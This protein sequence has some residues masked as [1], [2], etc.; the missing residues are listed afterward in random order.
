MDH[1]TSRR[2]RTTLRGLA[3]LAAGALAAGCAT[4]RRPVVSTWGEIT[5]P[6][7]GTKEQA[8]YDGAEL[9]AGPG[10]VGADSFSG[11]LPN[12]RIVTPAGQSLQ[13]GM[14]PL[15]AILTPDGKFLVTSNDDER[16]GAMPSLRSA[17]VFGG[18]S[19]S[20]IDTA[21]WKVV[22]EVHT[23]G[24]LFLGLA[25]SGAGP[26]T[27]YAAGGADS[28]VK[29]FAIDANGVIGA[30]PTRIPIPVVTS[31]TAGYVSHYV[32]DAAFDKADAHGRKPPVPTGFARSGT[33]AISFPAG[34]ALSPD[35]RCLYVAC[36]GDNSLA[37]LDTATRTVVKQLP[38]GFFPYDVRVS[39]D[40]RSV[41]VT[42][43]GI[44][45]YKFKSPTYDPATGKLT[46]LG[47]IG[48]NQPD[49]FYTPVTDTT[50][51]KARTSS[52]WVFSVPGGDPARAT[53]SAAQYLGKPLDANEQVG[54]T[55][56][57]AAALVRNGNGAALYVAKANDDA[58]ALVAA[59]GSRTVEYDLPLEVPGVGGAARLRGTYP[60]ALAA[61]GD[62][63]RIYVA[64]AGI[65]AVA[66]L[67][68]TS[69]FA[70]RLLGRIPTGWY[71]SALALSGDG[72]TLY[73]VNAKGVGE[74]VN[75]RADLAG[76][77]AT[78]VESFTDGN[79]IFGT[80]QR[81]DLAGLD[82]GAGAAMV[83]ANNYA[84]QRDLDASVVPVGGAASK[85]ISHVIFILQENKT[86][87]SMLGSAPQFGAFAS[88]TFHDA[89]G[90]RATD[91]QFTAVAVN[92]QAL[93]TA[94][95]TAVNYY[96]DSDESDAGHQFA[97]SGTATDYTEKTLL[98]KSG[99]GLLVNKN[100]EPEDYPAS[101][102]IFNNAARNGVSFKDYGAMVRLA[103]SDTGTSTPTSLNDPTGQ[104]AG[105]PASHTAAGPN[106]VGD[107]TSATQG[108]GQ[109]YFMS[110]P[111]LAALGGKNANGEPRFDPNYPGYTFNISDQRRAREFIRDYDAMVRRG[112]L[113]Q[114]L[115]VY[116]PNDH[117]GA[118]QATNVPAATA[119]Q[120]VADGDV[121]L[122]MV[123]E[124]VMRSP[125]YY[126]AATGT[127][128][129]I[130]ITYDDAQSTR[131]HLHEH[132]TPAIVVSP[133][134]KPAYAAKRHYS[135]ASIVKTEELL[136]GLPP[137]NL[138][139]LMATDLRDLFQPS[140]NGITADKLGFNAVAAYTPSPEGRRIWQLVARL[141]T[142]AADRDSRRLG[143]LGRLSLA[144][145]RLHTRAAEEHRLGTPAYRREQA[146]LLDLAE[147]AVASPRRDGDD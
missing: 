55:H 54:D 116:L 11:V 65:N 123:V 68:T 103:G 90:A 107:V 58:L 94:F 117:T 74:D 118:Q 120:Q 114:L 30:T 147:R 127:G 31:A 2:W 23:A 28:D 100:F 16:D 78:G 29:V 4:A 24:K 92:T 84:T 87:D 48:A 122:G 36:N 136:L 141:D 12:G 125:V 56:P 124:H 101:G 143:A 33:T 109:S 8:P 46:A 137:N 139:D 20:V 131:D 26:Y 119:A 44:T 3:I 57:S 95:A 63:T 133:F 6:V 59:D 75:P 79:F 85:R 98:V 70:P 38:V 128:A 17:A 130:F 104:G 88:T 134:A 138:G 72:K 110:V 61:S 43:W 96:S 121:A 81:V 15:G 5:A 142:S 132:R 62:G 71:P 67:D 102:Y 66:V 146:H 82:L 93:A 91:P 7:Y 49:G 83:V 50:A 105:Y 115:Y 10:K 112:T 14:N 21:R 69:P 22:S 51:G 52:A 35:G 9:L 106:D 77:T 97:A 126:D 76:T 64:E 108:F 42:N 111:V 129:A 40:G 145:D 89:T 80:V 37:V 27:L 25:V 41:Y 19:L 34:V 86:F 13:I 140:Y 45:E 53:F 135:T 47:A 144:A 73:V 113:P 39:G 18:Y 99:R 60:N 32:P 1:S